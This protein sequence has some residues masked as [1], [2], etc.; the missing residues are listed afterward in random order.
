[1][2]DHLVLLARAV[3]FPCEV[4]SP[5]CPGPRKLPWAQKSSCQGCCRLFQLRY[6]NISL[7]YVSELPR[8]I[9]NLVY[10]ETLDV[11]SDLVELPEFVTCL[12]RMARLFV[13]GGTKLPDCIGKM[14]KLQELGY[15]VNI[16][17]QSL[18]FVEELG[19][20]VNLRKLSVD[21]DSTDPDKASYSKKEML[22]SSLLKLDRCKLQTLSIKFLFGEKNA[23]T[24]IAGH[25]FLIPALQ[26]IREIDLYHGQLCWITKW[27]LSL[28]NLEK[29]T[30]WGQSIGQ[31]DFEM[32]GSIPSLLKFTGPSCLEPTIII[33]SSSNSWRFQQLQIFQFNL[34]VR[35]FMF[36]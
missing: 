13:P 33:S 35:E 31:Q 11:S 3:A 17:K 23:G 19:K 4:K 10:L 16:F 14:E 8:Q 26:S 21:W 27:M 15:S 29:L 32:V 18:K 1:M 34:C 12:K 6:L 20:L 25:P 28:P 2:L 30:L 36:E 24:L 22:V 5:A 9:G 7:S